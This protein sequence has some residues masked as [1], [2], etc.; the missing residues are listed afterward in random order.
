MPTLLG[1]FD[2]P[3]DVASA[4]HKLR[5]RG[6]GD[7]ETY[8]PAPFEEVDDAVRPGPSAVRYFTLFGGLTGLITGFLV[9]YVLKRVDL[10]RLLGRRGG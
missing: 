10:D 2:Q 8:S 9:L 1:V 7:I 5:G 3:G 4:V 6:I